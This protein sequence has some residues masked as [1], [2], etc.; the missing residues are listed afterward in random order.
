MYPSMDIP[1]VPW[2]AVAQEATPYTHP[3]GDI[4][5]FTLLPLHLLAANVASDFQF[6]NGTSEVSAC[7]AWH[8]TCCGKLNLLHN[9]RLQR[10]DHCQTAN[11]L[12]PVAVDYVRGHRTTAPTNWPWDRPTK[13]I[14]SNSQGSTDGSL[15]FSFDF[16]DGVMANHLFTCNAESLQEDPNRLFR[17]IQVDVE[18][19]WRAGQVM[20][21]CYTYVAGSSF[22]GGHIACPWTEVPDCITK[23]RLLMQNRCSALGNFVVSAINNL[24]IHAWMKPGSK[25]GCLLSVKDSAVIMLCL[26]ADVELDIVPRS[27]YID[28]TQGADDPSRACVSAETLSDVT[29]EMAAPPDKDE[30]D[31]DIS[32]DE[33]DEEGDRDMDNPHGVFGMLP[34]VTGKSVTRRIAKES[35]F[36]TL[37]HG[38]ILRLTGD[39]FEC[40]LR[41]TG[42]SMV[43]VGT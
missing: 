43:L 10:C 18:L 29:E 42:I 31:M 28:A 23:A 6:E 11:H 7:K 41:R 15:A 39:D 34:K 16:G 35:L 4:P 20:G 27:Q 2:W 37:V 21:S 14:N 33:V 40:T 38:D 19:A 9:M 3:Q 30:V 17:D 25:K 22:V 12:P 1:L 8:C 24:Q 5:P 13:G 26:G 36:I 32:E